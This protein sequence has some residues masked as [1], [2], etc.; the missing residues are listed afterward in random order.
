M[1]RRG[2]FTKREAIELLIGSTIF[3]VIEFGF[4]GLKRMLELIVMG[5]IAMVVVVVLIAFSF[6]SHE[7]AH[8]ITA[9]RHGYWASFYFEPRWA[10]IS[11]LTLFLPIRIIAV[12]AVMIHAPFYDREATGRIAM[13]GPLVNLLMATI[14]GLGVI[15]GCRILR[16]V[17]ILNA[18]LALFN[19]LP[20][21]PLDGEKVLRWRLLM[22]GVLF[23]TSIALKLLI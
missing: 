18:D 14:F 4:T 6:I 8:K 21:P 2:I 3:L 9:I 15:L 20:L 5:S 17:A 12:G 7:V 1:L 19:L 11:L 13:A 23:G 10:I 22:W 16:L